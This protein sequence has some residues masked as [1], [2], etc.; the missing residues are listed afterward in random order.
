[1]EKLKKCIFSVAI[2]TLKFN[3]YGFLEVKVYLAQMSVVNCLSTFTKN[4]SSESTRP[5]SFKVHMQ[6]SGKGLKKV[7]I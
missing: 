6:P 1:M 4:F 7:Y 2:D 5:I 3:P